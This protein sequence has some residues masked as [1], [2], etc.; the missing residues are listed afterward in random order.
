MNTSSS[1]TTIRWLPMEQPSLVASRDAFPPKFAGQPTFPGLTQSPQPQD[2]AFCR[3]SQAREV[4]NLEACLGEVHCLGP[5]GNCHWGPGGCARAPSRP[6]RMHQSASRGC[7]V[8]AGGLEPP[9]ALLHY[10]Y[11]DQL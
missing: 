9:Q 6:R 7:V 8:R 4:D 2:A 5:G 3:S 1:T 11:S 10:A